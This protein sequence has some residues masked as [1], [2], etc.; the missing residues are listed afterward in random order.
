MTVSEMVQQLIDRLGITGTVQGATVNRLTRA[1]NLGKDRLVGA[2]KWP[3]LE[4]STQFLFTSGT[5][6][7]NL[8]TEAHSIISLE[9]GTASQV[10]KVDR[11]TYDELYRPSLS[12][13]THP[14]VYVQQGWS[15]G[16]RM[17]IHI[18]PSPSANN[19]GTLR[20]VTSVPDIDSAS[21]TSS[22]QRIPSGHHK[23]LVEAALA[24]YYA[25]QGLDSRWQIANQQ[26]ADEV[27][28]LSG[29]VQSPVIKDGSEK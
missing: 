7:Y 4:T 26:F 6:T 13:A 2:Y 24:E 18:W 15:S 5:R 12:T 16:G 25:Q 21:S 28:R 10:R 22:F 27:D 1:V 20:Y 29:R 11:D 23:A 8:V 17:E 14:S 3:W 19:T 9:N